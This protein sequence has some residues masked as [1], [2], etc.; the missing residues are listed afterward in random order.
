MIKYDI[1]LTLIFQT[2]KVVSKLMFEQDDIQV[3]DYL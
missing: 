2:T 1:S 3:T